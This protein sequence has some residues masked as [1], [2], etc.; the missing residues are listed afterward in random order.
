M[1]KDYEGLMMVILAKGV[2]G[3]EN[4]AKVE[5]TPIYKGIVKQ[6]FKHFK[7]M[8]GSLS[9]NL[10]ALF[11]ENGESS[12]SFES[13]V[14]DFDGF[15]YEGIPEGNANMVTAYCK[16]QS[17]QNNLK[18]IKFTDDKDMYSLFAQPMIALLER[19]LEKKF[20]NNFLTEHTDAFTEHI[21]KAAEHIYIKKEEKE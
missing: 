4:M 20:W 21:T 19:L 3:I 15:Y 5:A 1:E 17:L 10:Y 6:E 12:K 13:L 16:L 2:S 7:T 9:T 8:Y 11:Y 14:A 18:E